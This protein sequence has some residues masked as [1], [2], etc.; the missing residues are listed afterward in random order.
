MQTITNEMI[1]A[2]REYILNRVDAEQSY[3]RN[4]EKYLDSATVVIL[5]IMSQYKLPPMMLTFNNPMISPRIQAILDE[6]IAEIIS[7]IDDLSVDNRKERKKDI[8]SYVHEEKNGNTVDNLTE[9]YVSHFKKELEVGI[10]AGLILG[11]KKEDILKAIRNYRD[12][13]WDNPYVK[14]AQKDNKGVFAVDFN[15]P[16]YGHGVPTASKKALERMGTYV[17]ADAWM[18]DQYEQNKNKHKWYKVDRGSS[19]PCD[20]CDSYVGIHPISDRDAIPPYHQ[21]CCCFVIYF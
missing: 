11:K 3:S 5:D 14:S 2:A 13:P 21:N 8:L 16:H 18:E 17:I 12:N 9:E 6:L 7:V 10:V 20:L 19:Y 15:K 1:D 4:I